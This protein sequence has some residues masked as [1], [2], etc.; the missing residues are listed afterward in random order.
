MAGKG[1]N[2][3]AIASDELQEV[4]DQIESLEAEKAKTADL[5]RESYAEAKARG[6]D[7]K[8]VRKLIAVRKRP[9][10]YAEEQELLAIYGSALGMGVFA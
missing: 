1:H 8:I 4:I 2:S 5:I 9:G 6:Y 7:T 3:G 10:A